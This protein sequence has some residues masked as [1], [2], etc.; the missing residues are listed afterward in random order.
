MREEALLAQ[1]RVL[2]DTHEAL[3]ARTGQSFNLFSIL[4]RE[5]DEVQ[6]HSAILAELLNPNGSHGQGA[7]FATHF[8]RRFGIDQDDI[9][10]AR[11]WAERA[12]S[13]ESRADILMETDRTCVVIE[14]K[15]YAADQ[16]RQLE[17]Y[18]AYASQWPSHRVFYLTL[19][20]DEP[21]EYTLGGLA[22]DKVTS[23]SHKDDVV[24]WLEDCVKEM[25]RLPQIREIL[26]HYQALLRK[27]TGT[28]TGELTMGLKKLLTEKAGGKR[29]FELVPSLVKAMTEL[30][31]DTEWT[32][33]MRLRDRLE[34]D[35]RLAYESD[36]PLKE[37]TPRVIRHAHSPSNKNKWKYGW[38]FRI[39][40][41]KPDI[42]R[43]GDAEALLRIDC[44]EGGTDCRYGFVAVSQAD[45]RQLRRS[46]DAN[47]MFDDWAVR[48][49]DIEGRWDVTHEYWLALATER[50]NL[51][52]TAWLSPSVID[53]L[54]EGGTVDPL[55][56]SVQTTLD[57]I[58]RTQSSSA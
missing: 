35:P 13:K 18:H 14:N 2:T 43:T 50:V 6:T 56:E 33:W 41:D 10:G 1:A 36:T 54:M 52:K 7:V 25:A 21:S 9:K 23:I 48:M 4:D 5:T 38:M 37:V 8:A 40:C 22:T 45:R 20:G 58:T 39:V 46:E 34:A 47:R 19:Y 3:A 15:I 44:A 51:G 55:V 12:I 29:N 28:A 11:V 31:V 30:S 24:E 53:T 57:V 32:F 26:T 17:R 27:L 16:P 49:A 42:F